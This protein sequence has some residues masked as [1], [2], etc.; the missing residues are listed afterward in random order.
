MDNEE[1]VKNRIKKRVR[2]CVCNGSLVDSENVNFVELNLIARWSMPVVGCVY[3]PSAP[4]KAIAVLCDRCIVLR[5]NGRELEIKCAVEWT[6]NLGLVKYHPVDDMVPL[7]AVVIKEYESYEGLNGL[8]A[9][10]PARNRRVFN[11]IL[12]YCKIS[13][14]FVNRRKNRC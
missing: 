8:G 9:Q 13:R 14:A 12:Q 10:Y 3:M 4:E 5:L 11:E 1:L 2:C 7:P 6:G